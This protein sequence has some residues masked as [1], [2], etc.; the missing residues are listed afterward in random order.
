[1]EAITTAT[2]A[3]EKLALFAS[4]FEQHKQTVYRAAYRILHNAD[5]AEDVQQ[6]VFLKVIRRG[7]LPES[8][9]KIKSFLFR[10]A[11]NEAIDVVRHRGLREFVVTDFE[12]VSDSLTGL[13]DGVVMEALAELP[14]EAIEM[15]SLQ[16]EGYDYREIAEMLGKSKNAVGLKLFHARSRLKRLIGKKTR[17]MK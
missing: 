13:T 7:R 17:R 14:P 8:A 15:L 10:V 5:D 11:T 9:A 1:M 16:Q 4:I 3:P 2:I 12:D 6:H